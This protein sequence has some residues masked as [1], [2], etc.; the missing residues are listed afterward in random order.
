VIVAAG[1]NGLA[2]TSLTMPAVNPDVIAV[3]AADSM[4]TDSRAD[5]TV[6]DFTNRGNATRHPDVLAPGRSIVSLRDPESYIDRTYPGARLSTTADPAQRFFRGSGTSQAAAMVSGS[7]ALLLEQRPSLT[8]DQVKTLLMNT[9]DPVTTD[10]AAGRGQINIARAAATKSPP[11]ARQ[12]NV[13]STGL[14]SLELSRGSAHVYDESTGAALTGE[15]D[16]F[17]KAWNA[18]AWALAS[19]TQ[20]SWTNGTFNG[21]AWTGSALGTPLN[22]DPTWSSVT[23]SG[24]TW[25]GTT[26][27]GRTWS[28]AVWTGRTWSGTTWSGR[29]W[30]G[31]TWSA[32][33]W[34]GEP[35]R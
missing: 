23:W 28:S 26:W 27:S 16:I 25:A 35:W 13:T 11:S 24:R 9:A 20:T 7:V 29:T 15:R 1:N 5:D 10:I 31:R 33:G 3:G 8:P 19:R 2:S 18:P 6:A 32:A 4:G 14:G 17:G 12:L 21:S 34:T 22:G 30:S